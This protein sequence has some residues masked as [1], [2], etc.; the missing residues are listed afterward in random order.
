MPWP[1]LGKLIKANDIS[2]YQNPTRYTSS[3]EAGRIDFVNYRQRSPEVSLVISR[4]AGGYSGVDPDFQYN[5]DSSLEAGFQGAGYMNISP[6]KSLSTLLS[7]WKTS[8]GD[9]KPKLLF[10]D[11]ELNGGKEPDVVT[12]HV[13]DCLKMIEDNWPESQLE[14]YTANWW[15][16]PNIIHGWE[17]AYGLWTAHY[18][19]LVQEADGDWRVAWTFEEADATL[20]I[21]NSFTPFV[22]KGWTIDETNGWQF[23]SSLNNV[24]ASKHGR[25]DGD[26]FL[27]TWF[28]GIFEEDD[29]TPPTGTSDVEVIYDPNEV[30]VKLTELAV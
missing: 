6:K 20:P 25:I 27:K 13:Q 24:M 10:L 7:W 8:L 28:D 4:I 21:H 16:K 15:W 3:P 14:I 22:A 19:Y 18:P 9:R 2:I 26:Y 5:Y 30:E 1:E 29:T 12:R 23:T 17:S 11:C